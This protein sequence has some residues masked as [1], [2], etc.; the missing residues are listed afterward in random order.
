MND[1][2]GSLTVNSTTDGLKVSGE[3]DSSTVDHLATQFRIAAAAGEDV[4]IDMS[5]VEFID[6]SGLRVIIEA[7]QLAAA[8]GRQFVIS[9]PSAIVVRL[10]EISGLASYLNVRPADEPTA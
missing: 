9:Q 2:T 5:D 10:L 6:S 1:A 7:H 3:I 4:T 8:S